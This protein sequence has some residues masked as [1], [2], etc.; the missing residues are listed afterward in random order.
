VYAKKKK[1]SSKQAT[2]VFMN[3]P[4]QSFPLQNPLQ[5]PDIFSFC[6]GLQKKNSLKK[7]L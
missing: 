1:A 2:L 6:S 7:V 5:F 4:E 3:L